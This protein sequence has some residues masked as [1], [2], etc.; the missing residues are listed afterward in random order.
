MHGHPMLDRSAL[1]R[2]ALWKDDGEIVAVAHYESRVGEAFF[3]FHPGYRHLR[4]E[5]LDYAEQHLYGVSEDG[6]RTVRVYVNDTDEEFGSLVSGRGYE[7]DEHNTRPLAQFIIPDPFPRIKLPAGYRLT[8][9]A[10]GCEWGKVHRVLFRG[11]N[12]SGEPPAGEA[13]LEERRRMFDTPK[14][15]RYLK[16]FVEAPNSDFVSI[17]GMFFESTH[18]YAYVEPVATDPDYRR[19]GLGK[20]AVLE[21]IRRCAALGASVAYVGSDQEFYLSIGFKVIYTSECW[22]KHL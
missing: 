3:Q 2:I 15:R 16:I 4:Q 1:G 20:A 13:E 9:L 5:M 17:C 7:K 8:S 19:M 18:H 14:A 22:E 10:E 6:K 12:N 21:G 11:F